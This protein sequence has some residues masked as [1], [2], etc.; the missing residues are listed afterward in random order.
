MQGEEAI[1]LMQAVNLG[2]IIPNTATISVFDGKTRSTIEL[3]SD[4]SSSELIRIR[5][6]KRK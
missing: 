6:Q 1:L 4:L 2:E 5:R 3:N